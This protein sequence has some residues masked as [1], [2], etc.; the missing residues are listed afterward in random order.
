MKGRR[1]VLRAAVAPAAAASNGS[2][3]ASFRTAFANKVAGRET[4]TPEREPD[5]AWRVAGYVVE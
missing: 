4:V 1:R 5:G 3:T 2:V